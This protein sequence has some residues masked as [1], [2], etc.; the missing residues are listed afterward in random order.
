M[1]TGQDNVLGTSFN[2]TIIGPVIPIL[3]RPG[4][5]NTLQS[6][7]II[8]GDI[9]TDT[10]NA[11]LGEGI[12]VAPMIDGVEVFNIT[13]LSSQG[14]NTLDMLDIF[15]AI[16]V[17]SISS[18]NSL[19]L[20]NVGNIIDLGLLSAISD[21]TVN[22]SDT[23]LSGSA[24]SMRLILDDAFGG[25]LVTI[26]NFISGT[27]ETLNITSGGLT[28]NVILSGT[29]LASA[30]TVNITGTSN[31]NLNIE[32]QGFTTV[33]ASAL[34]GNLVLHVTSQTSQNIVTGAGDDR[35]IFNN[36]NDFRAGLS[37]TDT[38]NAGD[39]NDTLVIDGNDRIFLGASEWTNVSHF[40]NLQ[41]IGTNVTTPPLSTFLGFNAYNLV[42]TNDLIQANGAGTLHI[43]NDNDVNNDVPGFLSTPGTIDEAGVTIDARSLNAQNHFSYN[44]EEGDAS[45]VPTAVTNDRFIFTDANINGGNTIDGGA[46]DNLPSTNSAANGDIMEVRNTATV[47]TGDMQGLSN[48][49]TIAGVND[50]VVAQTLDLE[51]TDDVIDALVDSYHIAT[52]LERETIFVRMN[53]AADIA[54]PLAGMGL[55]LD[56]TGMS[57]KTAANVTLDTFG[58]GN[59][60]S[61]AIKLGQGLLTVHNFVLGPQQDQ[62]QLSVSEFGLQ[63]DTDDIGFIAATDNGFDGTNILF[64]GSGAIAIAATHRIIFEDNGI[65]T[66]IYFDADGS[67]AGAQVLIATIVGGTGLTAADVYIVG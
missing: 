16:T 48:I 58:S 31:L 12:V 44:G 3:I 66:N 47:T 23:A 24:D 20:N 45:A 60:S 28:N 8:H 9:G 49:G 35:V 25:Q 64:G 15:G 46:V 26:N 50:Q 6:F 10:L 56:A 2:D 67:G 32:G 27:L 42:L 29:A 30:Q 36:P 40:E 61:N 21:T 13:S 33:D 39:G 52:P 4:V 54:A 19:S 51:L 53:A 34:T 62:V 43:I 5:Q 7:D 65:D 38:V 18:T 1:T 41:I 22:Y 55:Y 37:I 14:S 57:A 59:F 17:N 11:E 63:L